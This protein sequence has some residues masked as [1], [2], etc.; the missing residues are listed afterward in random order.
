MTELSR[1]DVLGLI[2]DTVNQMSESVGVE[3]EA[4]LKRMV[5]TFVGLEKEAQ[6]GVNR[7][8]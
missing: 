6:A 2:R 5:G 4:V 8:R 3:P 1:P 7:E